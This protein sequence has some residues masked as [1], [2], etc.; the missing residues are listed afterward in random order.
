MKNVVV[1]GASATGRRVY[2][3]IKEK[4]HVIAFVDENTALYGDRIDGIEII[5]PQ[6]IEK[7]KFDLIILAVLSKYLQIKE[8]LR[9]QGIEEEKIITQYVDLP[10]RAREDF[11]YHIQHMLME[12]K[13]AGAVAELGVYQ[14]EF[15]KVIGK[16]FKENRFYL[17]DTFEGFPEADT[18][19]DIMDSM[20]PAQTGYFSNTSSELVLSKIHNA[21]R[22]VIC[23]GYFPDT[24]KDV[25]DRFIFV[26]LDADLYQPTKEG[27]HFFY[28]RLQPKG[29]I[30]VHD[31]F[32]EV[33]K[34]VKKAVDEFCDEMKLTALPIGDTLSIA[35]IK[36]EVSDY[37]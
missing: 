15:S 12:K 20:S 1:F 21:D 14:G 7:L 37:V 18:S 36:N 29:V 31:Y 3:E 28:Q 19:V 24:A 16:Y 25:E 32:S 30:L 22:C 11:V 26:N 6:Q 13:I 34:G 8:M 5:S 33:Y 27:L 23:K 9:E 17:F 2:E 35:I 10:N 4:Y